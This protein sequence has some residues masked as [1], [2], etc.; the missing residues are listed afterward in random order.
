VLSL[1]P[2]TLEWPA[3]NFSSNLNLTVRAANPFR[4]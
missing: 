4:D 3:P 2:L 1:Y